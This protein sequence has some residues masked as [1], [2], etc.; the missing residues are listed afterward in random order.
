MYTKC[1]DDLCREMQKLSL[2]DD[3]PVTDSPPHSQQVYL[4]W[5]RTRFKTNSTSWGW[6][7]FWAKGV[8]RQ[9]WLECVKE[10][11][12]QESICQAWKSNV[13]NSQ[14]GHRKGRE[15]IQEPLQGLP[16]VQQPLQGVPHLQEP[17]Q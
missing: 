6:R 13:H 10:I 9:L 1:L 4:A 11:V 2:M 3:G 12:W 17:L 7:V 8:T 14:K 5:P 16:H 15:T